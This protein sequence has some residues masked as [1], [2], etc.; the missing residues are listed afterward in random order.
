MIL[1]EYNDQTPQ[2][3][4]SEFFKPSDGSLVGH[5]T[6]PLVINIGEIRTHSMNLKVK[7]AGLKKED[8]RERKKI[9]SLLRLALRPPPYIIVM[10]GGLGG[11]IGGL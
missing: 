4:E 8:D 2:D 7:F 6:L 5:E 11:W 1:F 10:G 3:Y 9:L